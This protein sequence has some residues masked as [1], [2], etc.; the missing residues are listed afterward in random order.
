MTLLS[1]AIIYQILQVIAL[2]FLSVYLIYKEIRYSPVIGDLTQRIGFVQPNTRVGTKT[3][4]IHAVSVGEALSIEALIKEIKKK[5]PQSVIYMTTGTTAGKRIAA[6]YLAPDYLSLMPYDFLFGVLLAF[7]RIKPTSIILIE[8]E[9]WPNFLLL[10]HHK[11]TPIYLLNARMNRSF[12]LYKTFS[13]FFTPILNI[14]D[15]FYTQSELDGEKFKTL[16]IPPQ[17]I[18]LLGN[19]KAFNVLQ[20][21]EEFLSKAP[22]LKIKRNEILL[23]GSI[24]PGELDIYLKLFIALKK[25]F[26][27]LTLILAPRHFHWRQ[28]LFETCTKTGFTIEELTHKSAQRIPE[29]LSKNI[30]IILIC[31]LGE[32]FKIYPYANIFYLGGTFV[33]I[34][35]HNLLEP[36]VWANPTIIGPWHKNCQQICDDLQKENA[37]I[38]VSTE[39][40]L[41]SNTQNLLRSPARR[42]QM[43]ENAYKWLRK[44]SEITHKTIIS[45]I[46][47]LNY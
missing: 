30:D 27:N 3:I 1:I 10:A 7:K 38:V 39:E 5:D 19:I 32:L 2:P 18:T 45:L 17:K 9:I 33:P 35:G 25:E 31:E 28:K 47:K 29:L 24:H 22:L 44:E 23:V 14:F 21:Q 20:K 36:A 41:L 26:T 37:L 42:T 4:W 8:A 16:N 6:K 40:E 34:G 15:H 43:G 46:Q 12:K 11:K 13:F